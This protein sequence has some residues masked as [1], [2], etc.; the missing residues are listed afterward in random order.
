MP[1][2]VNSPPRA[3]GFAV[4]KDYY[5]QQNNLVTGM[6]IEVWVVSIRRELDVPLV[7][8][9]NGAGNFSCELRK[10]L[11]GTEYAWHPSDGVI[12][13]ASDIKGAA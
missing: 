1:A 3:A 4:G 6:P 11:D 10:D 2:E 9:N 13:Y 5:Q 7:T 12:A 8:L